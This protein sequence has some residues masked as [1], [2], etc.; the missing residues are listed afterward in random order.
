MSR[1]PS[2]RTSADKPFVWLGIAKLPILSAM[3]LCS[4]SDQR[5]D[6][7]TRYF[8]TSDR[9]PLY[10]TDR[11]A[12]QPQSR[13]EQ[14]KA[15]IHSEE[16]PLT[17]TGDPLHARR[18]QLVSRAEALAM[19]DADAV[20]LILRLIPRDEVFDRINPK[21]RLIRYISNAVTEEELSSIDYAIAHPRR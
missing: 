5:L 9:R 16:K 19:E 4:C 15:A 1:F 17:Q 18:A 14:P 12:A 7:Q 8:A 11:I 20:C 10:E 13:Q 21:K 2:S 6:T 3:V